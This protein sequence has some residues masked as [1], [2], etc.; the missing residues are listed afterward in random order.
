MSAQSLVDRGNALFREGDVDGALTQYRAALAADP[1]N[2]RAH[3]NLAVVLQGLGRADEALP[4]YE[5]AAS[6]DPPFAPALVNLGNALRDRG[7]LARAEALYRRALSLDSKD[8]HALNNLGGICFG[9]GDLDEARDLYRRA[10]ECGNVAANV[11]LGKCLHHFGDPSAALER[12]RAALATNS[13]DAAAHHGCGLSLSALGRAGEALAHYERALD[14]DPAF[15]RTLVD[16]GDALA[17]LGRL[18]EAV[19]FYRRALERDPRNA[20]ASHNLAAV[21]VRKGDTTTAQAFFARA[22]EANPDFPLARYNAALMALLNQDFESGWEGYELRFE[23]PPWRGSLTPT[24]LPRAEDLQS[25]ER[26]AVRTEQGVGD[27][28]L[29]STL[30][31]ELAARG[32]EAVVEVDRRLADAYRRS[33]PGMRFVTPSEAP[34]SFA[35]CDHEIPM[36]SLPRLFRRRIEDFARQPRA[37][38]APDP[39]RV[40]ATA[41]AMPAGLRVGASWRSFRERIGE[42]KSF[43]LERFAVFERPGVTLV[44]LQYGDVA[45]EREAFDARHPGFRF[46]VPGLD[47]FAD[48]EGLLAAIEACDLVVTASNVTAHLAGAIGK[49]T[50]LVY[51]KALPQF[52]YWVPGPGGRCLW[53]PSVETLTDRSWTTWERAFEAIGQ[54]FHREHVS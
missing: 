32:I 44:D 25:V 23:V 29:F 31:P 13:R 11:G 21:S 15:N 42:S 22:A 30:L 28:I 10:V 36:G 51:L 54:R 49:R 46:D 41:S 50:W 16:W 2:A 37:I 52:H 26:L 19:A 9:R 7:D 27:R 33:V 48:L 34:A 4:H 12:Y 6:A 3:F 35:S 18:D 14:I 40:R 45:V 24:R 47:A 8:A 43:P 53:Y 39:A 5:R 1:Q 17:D 38:L 20:H